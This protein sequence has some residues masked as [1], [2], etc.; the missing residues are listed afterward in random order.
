MP[1]TAPEV[2]WGGCQAQGLWGWL[3]GPAT[4]GHGDGSH[5]PTTDPRKYGW[6]AQDKAATCVPNTVNISHHPPG[7]GCP[8]TTPASTL[9]RGMQT[10]DEKNSDGSPCHLKGG[11]ESLG[12]CME[13]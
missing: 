2:L 8:G 10:D 13:T 9:A 5:V 1:P 4:Q 12:Q 11:R 3:R 6:G 7:Q